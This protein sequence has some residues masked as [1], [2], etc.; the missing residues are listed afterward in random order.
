MR[1]TALTFIILT[2]LLVPMVNAVTI[3]GPLNFM[4]PHGGI[5]RFGTTTVT[6]QITIANTLYRFSNLVYGG[7]RET[8]G[9]DSATGQIMT[10]NAVTASEITYNVTGVQLTYVYRPGYGEPS[11]VDGGTYTFTGDITTVTPAGAGDITITWN[12]EQNR[13]F[14]NLLSYLSLATMIPV[15]IG[16]YYA[17]YVYQTGEFN[18][19]VA[20]A[21][22]GLVIAMVIIAAML[23]N[24]V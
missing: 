17:W 5:V 2:A 14:N 20:V 12:T 15:I 24:Y 1:K 22:A 6:S 7:N 13:L 19:G 10:I 11:Q 9:F 3:D 4:G 21:I 23:A 16:I 8:M 18:S